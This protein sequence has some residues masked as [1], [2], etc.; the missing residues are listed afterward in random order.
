MRKFIPTFQN[1]AMGLHNDPFEKCAEVADFLN[2]VL[3]ACPVFGRAKLSLGYV[4]QE[5]PETR[6]MFVSASVDVA[7][8][9][10]NWKVH[11]ESNESREITLLKRMPGDTLIDHLHTVARGMERLC[12]LNSLDAVLECTVKGTNPGH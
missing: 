12:R 2:Q 9:L 3:E 7:H 8:K 6:D 5:Y 4:K 1:I 10:R 11:G